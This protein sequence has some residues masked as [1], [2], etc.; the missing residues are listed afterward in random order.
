VSVNPMMPVFGPS[1]AQEVRK[2][3]QRAA[4]QQILRKFT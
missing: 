3:A 4:I 1:E 2:T